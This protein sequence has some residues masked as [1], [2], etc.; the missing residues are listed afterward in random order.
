M[1]DTNIDTQTI[2]RVLSERLKGKP[3]N[4][5]ACGT[6]GWFSGPDL[7]THPILQH[8]Q[9]INSVVIGGPYLPLAAMTCQVC[10]NTKLFN[11]VKLG[12]MA[13][14]IPAADSIPPDDLPKR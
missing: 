2:L 1:S 13:P 9:Q 11:L 7:I 14:F 8:G 10:G 3:L 5:D 12:L 6:S 4:C